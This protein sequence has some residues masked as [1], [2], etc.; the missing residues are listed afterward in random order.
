MKVFHSDAQ[1]GHAPRGYAIGGEVVAARE[2]PERIDALLAGER[3]ACAL[4]RSPGHHAYADVGAGFCYV[5]N[6]AVAAPGR[7]ST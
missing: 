4:C 1:A 6:A 2:T 7:A 3:E 5:N